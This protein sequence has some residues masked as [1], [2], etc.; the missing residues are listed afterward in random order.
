MEEKSNSTAEEFIELDVE[1]YKFIK[2]WE[3]SKDEMTKQLDEMIKLGDVEA[4]ET[5]KRV[6]E[7]LQKVYEDF[8]DYRK[9]LNVLS[10]GYN[11]EYKEIEELSIKPIDSLMKVFDIEYMR[12][13]DQ[14]TRSFI[15]KVDVN[16]IITSENETPDET[17]DETTTI[18]TENDT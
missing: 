15:E 10:Q 2:A 16:K 4:I 3:Y 13:F 6:L 5:R 17:P 7:I 12:N 11:L 1:A 14:R 8:M 9:M 18:I